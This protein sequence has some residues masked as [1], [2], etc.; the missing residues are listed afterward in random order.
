MLLSYM[1]PGRGPR[2][3]RPALQLLRPPGMPCVGMPACGDRRC[4]L[5]TWK[6]LGDASSAPTGHWVRRT[7]FPTVACAMAV[8]TAAVTI[9][10]AA[11]GSPSAKQLSNMLSSGLPLAR[12]RSLDRSAIS[13][14]VSFSAWLGS[15]RR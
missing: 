4:I 2:N 10:A 6:D 13:A 11:A 15:L 3:A 12:T 7:A 1:A 14:G 8:A 9:A 5:Q